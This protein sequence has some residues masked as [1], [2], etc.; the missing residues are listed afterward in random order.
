MR[1]Q[2]LGFAERMMDDAR[3]WVDGRLLA[4][5]G[6]PWERALGED[7]KTRMRMESNIDTPN[8]I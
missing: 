3:G 1:S 6:R 2:G 5:S 7:E 8:K 4:E